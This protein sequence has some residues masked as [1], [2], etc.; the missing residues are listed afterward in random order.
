MKR[1]LISSIQSRGVI[2]VEYIAPSYHIIS[3]HPAGHN[4]S[5]LYQLVAVSTFCLA[6]QVEMEMEMDGS[7]RLEKKPSVVEWSGASG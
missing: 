2:I 5:V 1:I 7:S 3:Y 6:L 4:I